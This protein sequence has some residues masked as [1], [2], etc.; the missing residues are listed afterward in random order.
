M[1]KFNGFPA[2]MEFTSIPN[3][4]FTSLLPQITDMAE[5]KV[6]LHVLAA[7][8]RKKG[9]PRFVSFSEL[10]GDAALV[11]GLGGGAPEE[12]LRRA[13]GMAVARGTM[14][15]I[16]LERDGATE[17]AYLLNTEAN[18]QAADKIRNGEIK[19][20]GLKA[21]EPAYVAEAPPDIFTLYEENIGMLY[22]M[23][24]EELRDMEKS[25]PS[26]WIRDAIKE[27]VLH[28]KRNIRYISRILESWAA[29]GR[30]DGAHPRDSQKAG[31]A[32]YIK[33]RYGHMVQR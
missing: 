3:L 29:E 33:Q 6:T 20:S 1:K 8:Y 28:N 30:E 11:G 9:Y 23:A 25:Y 5:L 27:A 19:L 13:L 15:H 26:S 31:P 12:A 18:R 7:I 24:A 21:R 32:K 14:L 2:R 4:F 10:A 22:P 16:A 17:D